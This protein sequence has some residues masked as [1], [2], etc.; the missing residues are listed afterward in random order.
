MP[1]TEFPQFDSYAIPGDTIQW[2]AEGFDITATL[3]ADADTTPDVSECY[4][5]IKIK[6]WKNDEWFFVGI[7][8]SVSKND[9]VISDH[10]SSLWGIECNFNKKANKYLSEVAKELEREALDCAKI[11]VDKIL[12]ALSN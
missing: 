10:A 11:E 9:I 7:V 2:Q 8:I 6:Q 12:N 4:S 1:K 5:A 3:V